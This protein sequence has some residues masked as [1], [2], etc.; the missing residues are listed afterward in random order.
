M[1]QPVT[2]LGPSWITVCWCTPM[3][4]LYGRSCTCSKQL[5]LRFGLH[6]GCS[7]N[8]GHR[9]ISGIQTFSPLESV[10]LST[11]NF[12]H[13]KAYCSAL[14]CRWLPPPFHTYKQMNSPLMDQCQPF[15][16]M[17][18]LCLNY[19]NIGIVWCQQKRHLV[20]FARRQSASDI[21]TGDDM[22]GYWR[23]L[24]GRQRTEHRGH[25]LL[26]DQPPSIRVRI[27][28]FNLILNNNRNLIFYLVF[29][30]KSLWGQYQFLITG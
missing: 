13:I 16:P 27:I 19:I 26:L 15:V 4:F 11:T 12:L 30:G 7:S 18:W 21:H 5:W 8:I 2:K 22:V 14:H 25:L 3:M 24:L 10:S 20:V 17:L 9:A 23:R 1:L 29:T 28:I 6:S